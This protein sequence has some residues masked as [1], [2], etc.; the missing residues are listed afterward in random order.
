MESRK[1][2]QE[3]RDET[4]G[5]KTR[6]RREKSLLPSLQKTKRKK[7]QLK[8]K[9]KIPHASKLPFFSDVI[10][11]FL[12]EVAMSSLKHCTFSGNE[13]QKRAMSQPPSLSPVG[14]SHTNKPFCFFDFTKWQQQQSFFLLIQSQRRATCVC[15]QVLTTSR[16]SPGP[17]TG[18]RC[19][20]RGAARGRS[21]VCAT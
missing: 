9:K 13:S 11:C 17:Q 5:K 3:E 10:L 18:R 8:G 21:C 14:E 19:R 20:S 6:K 2:Q 15:E 7:S 12:I 4:K 16:E 1:R